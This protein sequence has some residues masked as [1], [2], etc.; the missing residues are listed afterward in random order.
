MSSPNPEHRPP[1]HRV[2]AMM[3]ALCPALAVSTHLVYALVYGA[4][5]IL[6]LIGSSVV[7]TATRDRLS[8]QSH[9]VAGFVVIAGLVSVVDL[10]LQAYLPRISAELG[11]YVPLIAVSCIVIERTRSQHDTVGTAAFDALSA[12]V[13]FTV[14]LVLVSAVRESLGL[15]T[16]TLLPFG[17]FDGVLVLPL[18]SRAPVR[19]VALAPG[20][21]LVVGYLV[22]L[23]SR[24]TKR[25]NPQ[26]SPDG[27]VPVVPG[28]P[29]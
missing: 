21:F 23:H 12:G 9:I 25:R 4:A 26:A 29:Q 28:A 8:R 10:L 19:M 3:L 15:G 11:I 13:A 16:L 17:D 24:L 20:A 27:Q 6:V 14:A 7:I 22:G 18:I 5:S 2:F 1:Y